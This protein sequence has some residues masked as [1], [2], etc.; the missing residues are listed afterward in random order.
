MKKNLK[1]LMLGAI[2]A[3]MIISGVV[4]F[5][6]D[7]YESYEYQPTEIETEYENIELGLEQ[8]YEYQPTEAEYG[9][10]ELELDLGLGF[11]YD[12]MSVG[13]RQLL[14]PHTLVMTAN[15]VGNF[16]FD[17]V[18]IGHGNRLN[19]HFDNMTNATGTVQV[20]R[21][22]GGQWV[23]VPGGQRQVAANGTVT[24]QIP[25]IVPSSE[26]RVRIFNNSGAN[27][28]GELGVR[29]TNAPL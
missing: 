11:S 7:G 6:A 23:G 15:G 1:K 19:V 16:L 5:A 2:A 20:E 8:G 14:V 25:S 22:A 9:F 21:L 28:S 17:T 3:I 13:T 27:I 4:L 26:H 10:D 24:W 12:D 18:G 29:Q